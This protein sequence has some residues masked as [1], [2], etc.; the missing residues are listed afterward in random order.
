L[1]IERR[2]IM[3][4]KGIKFTDKT[5]NTIKAIDEFSSRNYARLPVVLSTASNAVLVDTEGNRFIDMMSC[6]SAVNAGHGNGKILRDAVKQMHRLTVCSQKFYTE[7]EFDYKRLLCRICDMEVMMPANTG[8]EAWEAA[9]KIAR[10]WGYE[11]KGVENNK[12][13]IIVCEGNFHGRTIAAISA[14]TNKEYQRNF[15][16]LTPGFVSIPFGHSVALEKAINLYTAGFIV[17]PIQGEAGIIIPPLGFLSD[18]RRIC[19]KNNVLFIADEIQTGLGRTGKVFACNQEYVNPDMYILGKALGGGILPVSAV[20]TSREVM[21]VM[22][23]GSHGSTFAGNP[24]ACA[25]ATSFLKFMLEEQLP[26]KAKMMGR[27]FMNELKKI[28]SQYVKEIRGKGLFIGVEFKEKA[29][30]FVEALLWH[31][32]LTT[33]THDNVIRLAPPLTIT[34]DEIDEALVGIKYVLKGKHFK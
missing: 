26:K 34:K 8:V 21:D 33:E 16:P 3:T 15:G 4:K 23:P 22:D 32:V 20:V 11:K 14:S 30:R 31:G 9:V 7:V 10:R 18:A 24:F 1:T 28:E 19:S 6:Y 17:E 27:Y 12:A 2:M 5:C 25:V 29:K 13:E